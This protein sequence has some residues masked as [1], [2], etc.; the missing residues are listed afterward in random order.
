M[1]IN[2]II[3]SIHAPAKGATGDYTGDMAKIDISI[4]APAKGATKFRREQRPEH[5][6]S[7][8]APAKG[9]TRSVH[10]FPHTAYHFNPRSR[11]GSD[12][13]LERVHLIVQR[14]SIHAPAK[15]ATA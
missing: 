6:I 2:S 15:G 1:E 14:I 11:E 9:A 4:H 8:H 10:R 13:A 12:S 5:G 3:I 7:I